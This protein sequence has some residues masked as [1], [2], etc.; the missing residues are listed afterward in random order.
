MRQEGAEPEPVEPSG[1]PVAD[2]A[3]PPGE[4]SGAGAGAEDAGAGAGEGA[5]G[6]PL[7]N[8]R[9]NSLRRGQFAGTFQG[10]LALWQIGQMPVP[11]RA[12]VQ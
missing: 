11:A 12:Q 10:F 9:F 4:G 6:G 1:G 5:E 3:R 2:A 8:L 7:T